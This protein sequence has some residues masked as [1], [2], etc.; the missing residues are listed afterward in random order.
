MLRRSELTSFNNIGIA[1]F[2]LEALYNTILEMLKS[3]RRLSTRVYERVEWVFGNTGFEEDGGEGVSVGGPARDQ[4]QRHCEVG[5]LKI[6]CKNSSET[7]SS[8]L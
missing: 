6:Q 3:N 2:T 5:Y 1:R 8:K 7:T 4:S